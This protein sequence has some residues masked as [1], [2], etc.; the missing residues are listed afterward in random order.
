[1]VRRHG[2]TL[3]KSPPRSARN[4]SRLGLCRRAAPVVLVSVCADGLGRTTLDCLLDAPQ[5]VGRRGLMKHKSPAAL[6]VLTKDCRCCLIAKSAVDAGPIN[7]KLTWHILGDSVL[8][9]GHTRN[10]A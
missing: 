7:V 6:V 10:V 4:N 8:E 2:H 9:F 3:P 5:L 1:M